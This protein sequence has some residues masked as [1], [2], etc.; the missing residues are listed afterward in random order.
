MTPA[1]RFS[2][3]AQKN[4]LLAAVLTQ[5]I[6]YHVTILSQVWYKFGGAPLGIAAAPQKFRVTLLFTP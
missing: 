2:Y 1:R 5:F 6:S 3:R 4:P